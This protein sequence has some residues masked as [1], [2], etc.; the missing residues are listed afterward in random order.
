MNWNS[1]KLLKKTLQLV[2]F[3]L[4]WVLVEVNEFYLTLFIKS[5]F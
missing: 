2:I 1:S 4:V 3:G 5:V